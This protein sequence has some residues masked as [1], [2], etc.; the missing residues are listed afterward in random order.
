M[1]EPFKLIDIIDYNVQLKLCVACSRSISHVYGMV[2]VWFLVFR[3]IIR[4][5]CILCYTS[6]ELSR[7]GKTYNYKNEYMKYTKRVILN[8]HV[9]S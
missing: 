1:A 2:D 9:G 6:F 3:T 5:S 8:T 4:Y 7:K